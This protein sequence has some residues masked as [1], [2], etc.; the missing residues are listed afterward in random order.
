M[1]AVYLN[2]DIFA[3]G[4]TLAAVSDTRSAALADA[5]RAAANSGK[6][7]LITTDQ[8]PPGDDRVFRQAGVPTLGLALFRQIEME[9][10]QKVM[11]GEQVAN[12]PSLTRIVHTEE[13][14]PE[15]VNAEEMAR[16]L[17]VVE[18]AI[19]EID[20]TRESQR[21]SPGSGR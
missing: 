19:R 4:D 8:S 13:D 3:Y 5:V 18:A 9:S 17:T 14:T 10:L 11:R 6:F 21:Q 16:A 7:P 20:A 12:P 2:F 1:P 15:R